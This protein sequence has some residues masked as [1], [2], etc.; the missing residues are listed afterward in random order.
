MRIFFKLFINLDELHVGGDESLLKAELEKG[1]IRCLGAH[2]ARF[3]RCG[4]SKSPYHWST[5]VQ[6]KA[7]CER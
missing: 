3:I 5:S 6:G 1:Y 7:S 2:L 4:V